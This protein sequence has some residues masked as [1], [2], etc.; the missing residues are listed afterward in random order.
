MWPFF[1]PTTEVVTFRL[2][3][4]VALIN[5]PPPPSSPPNNSN[6]N[7][8]QQQTSSNNNKK[9]KHGK[10][11]NSLNSESLNTGLKRHKEQTKYLTNNADNED[12][13]TE[14][15]KKKREKVTK[16]KY[17]G[18]TSDHTFDLRK[19]KKREIYTRIIAAWICF[20][21]KKIYFKIYNFPYHSKTK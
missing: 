3:W 19:E 1:N 21:K 18:Q 15:E 6:N 12:I 14:Q 8:Q 9:T 11:L 10:A 5:E 20:G 13:L 2:R 17:L 7:K 4:Y 16:F